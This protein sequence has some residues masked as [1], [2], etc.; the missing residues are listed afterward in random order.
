MTYWV[1]TFE[2]RYFIHIS[3]HVCGLCNTDVSDVLSV[4]LLFVGDA[5][6]NQRACEARLCS[7]DDRFYSPGA[8]SGSREK[9]LSLRHSSGLTHLYSHQL[10][11]KPQMSFK[12]SDSLSVW[13][14]PHWLFDLIS[15]SSSRRRSHPSSSTG[16]AVALPTLWT[17]GDLCRRRRRPE[18]SVPALILF[19]SHIS[20]PS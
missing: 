4:A 14:T 8:F 11:V 10:I 1:S 18:P 6:T 7:R 3:R 19:F 16:A 17:V 9:L 20:N 15:R 13:L 5:G 2:G 12:G